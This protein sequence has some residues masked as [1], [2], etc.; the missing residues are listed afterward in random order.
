M[1]S[2]DPHVEFFYVPGPSAAEQCKGLS[3][4]I[5]LGNATTGECNTLSDEDQE[6]LSNVNASDAVS[7]KLVA[8]DSADASIE[9]DFFDGANCSGNKT[10]F[11][12][13]I[14]NNTC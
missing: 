12:P 6:K 10:T 3:I 2:C 8:C 11:G 14:G 7:Y 1:G 5:S 9:W 4:G 13:F